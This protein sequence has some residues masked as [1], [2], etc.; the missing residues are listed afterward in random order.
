MWKFVGFKFGFW[1]RL[2]LNI[3]EFGLRN[4]DLV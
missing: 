2:E 3:D 1:K 4:L